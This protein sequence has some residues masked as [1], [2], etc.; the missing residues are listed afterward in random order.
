MTLPYTYIDARLQKVAHFYCKK[1]GAA[2]PIVEERV[3]QL[4]SKF[5]SELEVQANEL[6][7]SNDEIPYKKMLIEKKQ[8]ELSDLESQKSK[9]HDFLERGI[10]DVDTF[11]ER[12]Q[13]LTERINRLQEEI[14]VIL[15]EIQKE[16][17][18]DNSINEYLPQLR[19]V[20][21]GYKSTDSIERKNTL[22]KEVL[23]KVTYL[24][25]KEWN[26][27]DEFVLQLYPRF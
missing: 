27:K 13:N 9:L 19:N 2:L 21:E 16:E 22:L 26:K 4:L 25:K 24:R 20:I 23:E 6:P 3:L 1:K 14:R 12:Q 15:K 18:R 11:I 7:T 10:Y 8:T 5:A 17:I